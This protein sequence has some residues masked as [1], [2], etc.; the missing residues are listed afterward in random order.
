MNKLDFYGSRSKAH[1]WVV[2][3]LNNRQQCVV[4]DGFSS[5][6]AKVLSDVPIGTVLGPTLFDPPH[7]S[8]VP[9][10]TVLGP[11]LFDPPLYKWFASIL[12]ILRSSL[13]TTASC[14]ARSAVAK[15]QSY[16]RKKSGSWS[17]TQEIALS[18]I[19][20][21][22]ASVLIIHITYTIQH[23]KPSNVPLTLVSTSQI[24]LIGPHT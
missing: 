18:S 21:E 17:L 8:D 6:C 11:T 20:Q 4:L 5:T 14:I 24:I 10:G 12:Y 16:G 13:R 9:I 19:L 1:A 2:A 22:S 3:F 23:Y 7:I 15:I